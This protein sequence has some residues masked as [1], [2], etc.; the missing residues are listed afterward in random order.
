MQFLFILWALLM[1]AVADERAAFLADWELYNSPLY[2]FEPRPNQPERFD[3]QSGFVDS[4]AKISVCLGGNGSGKTEAAAQK[5]ARFLLWHQAPPR[6]DT[7]FM[8]VSDTYHQVGSICW[9]EKLSRIIPKDQI[10]WERVV[11]KSNKEELPFVV[12]LK[13]W[14]GTS[15]NWSLEFRSLDQGR[16]NFQGRSY[17]GFWFS[18]QFDWAVFEEVLRGCRETWY[19]GAHIAEFTP[20]DPDLAIGFEEIL[21]KQPDGWAFFRLNTDLNT[22]ISSEWRDTFFATVSEEQL[23]TRRTGALP[24]F[25]G[26]IYTNFNQ[27]IHVLDDE[28]WE[29]RFGFALPDRYCHTHEFLKSMPVGTFFRRG[30]DWGESV[31]HP[32]VTLWGMKDGGGNWGIYDEY[33]ETTGTVLYAD[34]RAE[35]KRR[36]P[37]PNYNMRFGQTYMDPSRPGLIQEHNADGIPTQ[38]AGNAVDNGIEYVRN[39]L[40]PNVVTG[41]PAIYIHK[42]N[43]PR[44]IS[45][46]RKYRWVRGVTDGKNPHAAKRV[47]LKFKDDECDALRY[48]VYSD[49]TRTGTAPTFIPTPRDHTRHGVN[50]RK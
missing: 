38:P 50:F 25:Q 31:E 5:V 2:Q 3:E 29:R 26:A 35:V 8:V 45:G 15:N 11:W 20:I 30:G 10:D 33:C 47:P 12:P 16:E 40:K 4:K 41:Q 9:K 49:R 48:L 6:R 18:E 24:S 27:A 39:L 23:E 34:R 46:L 36:W 14:P 43:C 32:F 1:P 7:P 37:W 21:D 19:D 28:A 44:L 17:G 13:A 22:A 42:R